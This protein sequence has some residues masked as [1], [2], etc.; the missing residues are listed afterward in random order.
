MT[1]RALPIVALIAALAGPARGE[2][3]ANMNMKR[4]EAMPREQRLRLAKALEKFD[5]LPSPER[6]AIRDLDAALARLDPEVQARYRDVLRRYHVWFGGLD[7][8]QKKQLADAPTIDAKLAL[9]AKWRKAERDADTRAKKNL[10]FGVHPGDLGTLP[11]FEMANALRVWRELDAKQKAEIEKIEPIFPRRLAELTKVGIRKG[12]APHRFP[13]TIEDRLMDRLEADDKV[14]AAFQKYIPKREKNADPEAETKRVEARKG[15]PLHSLSESL[16]F[17]ETPA[18]PVSPA[19]LAQFEAEFPGW[20][21]ATLD[22][23]P[24][25]DARRRIT[26]LYRQIYPPGKEIPPPA[27]GEPSK[28]EPAKSKAETPPATK[29]ATTPAP[30]APF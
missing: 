28:A 10:V 4:L 9:V 30:A 13:R 11:P 22:P 7:D 23:L 17:V 5:L 25:E 14:K 29:P 6:A 21:R 2:D 18:E 24:P 8:P 27:T 26:I 20:L 3:P 1:P 12:I 16:Y 15:S 19:H